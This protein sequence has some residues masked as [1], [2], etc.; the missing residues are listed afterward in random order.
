MAE[1]ERPVLLSRLVDLLR[2]DHNVEI[3]SARSSPFGIGLFRFSMV[4]ARDTIVD[5]H[6]FQLDEATRVSFVRHDEALNYRR[7]PAGEERWILLIGF[8]L[9][10]QTD[11][12]IAQAC[13]SIGQNLLWHDPS[14]NGSRVLVRV[15]LMNAALIPRSLVLRQMGG[16]NGSWTV[17]VY[18]LRGLAQAEAGSAPSVAIQ[19]EDPIPPNGNPHPLLDLTDIGMQQGFPN[20]PAGWLP[21]NAGSGDEAPQPPPGS[22]VQ[23][24]TIPGEQ[25]VNAEDGSV[26]ENNVYDDLEDEGFNLDDLEDAGL[27][28]GTIVS[29]SENPDDQLVLVNVQH[30]INIYDALAAAIAEVQLNPIPRSEL[31]LVHR[32]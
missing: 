4:M 32:I 6:G 16:Q 14:G 5:G 31:H 24:N 27:D 30:A 20:P 18:L 11:A 9:D 7:T 19:M 17:P 13:I 26:P 1:L 21:N 23:L 22:L 3:H 29:E 10:Y 25:G 2:Y 15:L 28:F 8:P 12:T